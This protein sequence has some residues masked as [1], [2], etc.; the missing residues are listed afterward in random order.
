MATKRTVKRTT[1]KVAKMP[2][3]KPACKCSY[4]KP[5]FLLAISGWIVAI[6]VMIV[7]GI[8]FF[9]FGAKYGYYHLVDNDTQ[10]VV[11]NNSQN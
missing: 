11:E 3:A 7:F 8:L 4:E 6:A 9:V 2:T 5:N 1:S 10:T